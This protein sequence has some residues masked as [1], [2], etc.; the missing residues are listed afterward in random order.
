MSNLADV[1]WCNSHAERTAARLGVGSGKIRISEDQSSVVE[2][3]GAVLATSE[4]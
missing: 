3:T 1:L 2:A 4:T